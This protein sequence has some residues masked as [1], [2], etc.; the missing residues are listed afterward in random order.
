MLKL[1][2]GLTITDVTKTVKA[3]RRMYHPGTRSGKASGEPFIDV[4]ELKRLPW[5]ELISG[6]AVADKITSG[7][8]TGE[9]CLRLYV[10]RK[11]SGSR[12]PSTSHIP[13]YVEVRKG[14][15]RFRLPTDV[16]VMPQDPVAQ[17]QIEASA[18][19]GSFT[20]VTDGTFGLAV[21]DKTGA[22]IRPYV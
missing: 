18:A 10:R 11:I 12:L 7:A 13:R 22:N 6:F 3:V 19:I 21:A 15:E 2:D 9:L 17:R 20:G 4:R 5:D 8:P 16:V 1:A 14:K